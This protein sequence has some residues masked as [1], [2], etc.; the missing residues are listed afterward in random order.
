MVALGKLYPETSPL[1][2]TEDC[3]EGSLDPALN[4]TLAGHMQVS[5]LPYANSLLQ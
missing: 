1:S 5:C 3:Q 2:F 4:I